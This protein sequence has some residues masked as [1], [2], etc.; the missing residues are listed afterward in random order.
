MKVNVPQEYIDNAIRRLDGR[1]DSE[2]LRI[3][4]IINSELELRV[5]IDDLDS[6]IGL[7]KDELTLKLEEEKQQ[8]LDS[9]AVF[10]NKLIILNSELGS[11][12][13]T[14]FNE[15]Q[16]LRDT[17]EL[18]IENRLLGDSELQR[19]IIVLNELLNSEKGAY[20]EGDSELRLLLDS[21]S[22]ARE[23][24]DNYLVAKIDTLSAQQ[25]LDTSELR[26][27]I[28]FETSERLNQVN[29]LFIQLTSE[30]IVR[31]DEDLTLQSLIDSE[32]LIRQEQF[33][34]LRDYIDSETLVRIARDSEIESL[35]V[36]SNWST[37]SSTDNSYILN[38][39]NIKLGL[40]SGS[41]VLN[42]LPSGMLNT[43][44]NKATG[45]RSVAEGIKAEASGKY[46]HAEGENTK[47]SK[48][49][50]HAEGSSSDASGDYSHAEGMMSYAM[51]Q[52]S[53]AEGGTT[54]AQG[55]ESHAEGQ[56]T[57]AIGTASHTE[58]SSTYAFGKYSHAE[59]TQTQIYTNCGHV[60]G[61]WNAIDSEGKFADIVGWGS[62]FSR[63]K[64]ISSLTTTGDLHLKGIIYVNSNDDGTGGE[65]VI[66]CPYGIGGIYTTTISTDNPQALFPGTTWEEFGRV[67][68]ITGKDPFIYYVRTR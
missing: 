46:S 68:V 61:Q 26:E 40:G 66:A 27:R 47:A 42:Q 59:G 22:I 4:N 51:G 67:Q 3:Q 18:E 14:R 36:N 32:R 33:E 5:V 30:S 16:L 39:P 48:I 12:A 9:E 62:G 1:I 15:D 58:G 23:S 60:Q 45:I 63:R 6:E 37:E 49:A 50:A 56:S 52:A 35:I 13:Q 43:N 34:S 57:R 53:H 29:D 11:E 19:Q 38:R 41:V 28:S 20:I 7:V 17:I 65:K 10:N 55:N 24:F 8:R 54:Q 21:E 2:A 31:R 44:D 25:V 64:N